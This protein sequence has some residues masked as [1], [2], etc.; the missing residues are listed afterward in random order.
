[1]RAW[2]LLLAAL[3]FSGC[4]PTDPLE[5]ALDERARW[6]VELLNWAQ[7]PDGTITLSARVSG[8]PQARLD[9][10]TVRLLFQDAAGTELERRWWS[11]DLS[12][13]ERGGPADKMLRVTGKPGVEGIGIDPV[14]LPSDAELGEIPELKL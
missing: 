2:I 14:L 6:N 12:D 7:G 5:R 3:A 9:T 13:V 8:P 11:I 1:M 4:G 10:L